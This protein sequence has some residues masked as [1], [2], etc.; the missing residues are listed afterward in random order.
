MREEILNQKLISLQSFIDQAKQTSENGWL[1]KI[2]SPK[3]LNLRKN[4]KKFCL[5]LDSR[6]PIALSN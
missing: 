5:D 4:L 3:K 1:V 2:R 6:G